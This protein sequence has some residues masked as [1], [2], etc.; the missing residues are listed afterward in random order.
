MKI[1]INKNIIIYLLIL[2]NFKSVL[3]NQNLNQFKVEADNQLNI[4]KKKKFTLPQVM[5]RHQRET[6]Q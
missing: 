4:L 1:I 5:P 6:F 3:A 2:I